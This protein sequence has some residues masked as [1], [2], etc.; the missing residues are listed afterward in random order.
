MTLTDRSRALVEKIDAVSKQPLAVRAMKAE[1]LVR[2]A[3][4]LLDEVCFRVDALDEAL[5]RTA[6]AV[7]AL[8]EKL[9]RGRL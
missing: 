9:N 7:N 4:G 3:A 2:E 6:G 1:E 5:R 8:V